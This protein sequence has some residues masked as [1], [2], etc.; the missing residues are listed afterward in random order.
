MAVR[1][2][3]VLLAA[4][5]LTLL[6]AVKPA[7]VDDTA[8]L[9][10]ARHLSV[11]PLHPYGFHLYWFDAPQ[12][13][14]E[15][16]LPPVLPYWV[17]AGMRL[18][19]DNLFLLKLWLF[20]FAWVLCC[21]VAELVERFGVRS[22]HPV[23]A[24]PPSR[25]ETVTSGEGG[26]GLKTDSSDS[27]SALVSPLLP[28]PE[29]TFSEGKGLG[30]RA[31]CSREN[32]LRLAFLVFA[33]SPAVVP[34]F[35]VMLDIPALSLGA[36]A[37]AM[38]VAG[39]D[40]RCL[41]RCAL[42][43]VLAALAMQTKYSM[44]TAPAVMTAY[45]VLVGRSRQSFAGLAAALVSVLAVFAGW[46][47]YLLRLHGESHFLHHVL[48]NRTGK[49]ARSG[50]L[51]PL[52]SQFGGLVC[53]L[54]LVAG[55]A[56]GWP[57]WVRAAGGLFVVALFAVITLVPVRWVVI[58]GTLD[59]T[60]L[61]FLGCGV[62]A[63]VTVGLLTTRHVNR[64][65]LSHDTLFLLAW[66]FVETLGML[67]MTPFPAARR[68]V[69]V[70]LAVTVLVAHGFSRLKATPERWAVS[71]A[72]LIGLSVYAVDCW[73]A[74]PEKVLAVRAAEVARPAN[75]ET[76]WYSGHWGFQYYAE[77]Q[78]MTALVPGV[79]P[80]RAGD[81]LV[82]PVP[83]GPFGRPSRAFTPLLPPGLTKELVAE[84]K[85]EDG[86][87]PRSIPELYGGAVPMKGGDGPRLVVNVWRV[88][89][90]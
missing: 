55:R 41:W 34:L 65:G 84:L 64:L 72:V 26:R 79:N 90:R 46:E 48:A 42:A 71:I 67:G 40:R 28:S 78:G 89:N 52:F 58:T 14:M 88:M 44:L 33:F 80:I 13:A 18:F 32:S 51:V 62:S 21:S 2:L 66:V 29:V 83:Y 27:P 74:F 76:V 25:S 11:D 49:A 47:L 82:L 8:Y 36:A 17:A 20:P 24:R 31:E 10:F 57:G 63:V 56:A 38:F 61:G 22:P 35:N 86:F 81:W 59:A 43:G 16:L 7:V 9:H 50:L 39:T 70:H 60:H 85:W 45:A 19:G 4:A 37:I 3:H 53:G 77:R 87:R 1:P 69:G 5:A 15:I 30:V 12:P 23:A 54:S 6:N 73:D 75:D 68:L